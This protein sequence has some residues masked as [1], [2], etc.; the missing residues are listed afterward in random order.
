MD[1]FCG[2]FSAQDLAGVYKGTVP[3]MAR[4]PEFLK[5]AQRPAKH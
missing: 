5:E 3:L 1:G 2:C 4:M